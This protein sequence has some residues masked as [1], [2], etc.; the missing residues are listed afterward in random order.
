[1]TNKEDG[2]FSWE[3]SAPIPETRTTKGVRLTLDFFDSEDWEVDQR[4]FIQDTLSEC[5][6]DIDET[7]HGR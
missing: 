5:V 4:G 6:A 3:A 7:Y 2:S 1:M